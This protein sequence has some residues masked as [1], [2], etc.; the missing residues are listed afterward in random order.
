MTMMNFL[1]KRCKFTTQMQL[2]SGLLKKERFHQSLKDFRISDYRLKL[3]SR[4]MK[5]VLQT[6]S[7]KKKKKRA[8][9]A[10]EK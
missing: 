3:I 7:S 10:L 9:K 1:M 8:K 5:K 6:K 2:I 4:E